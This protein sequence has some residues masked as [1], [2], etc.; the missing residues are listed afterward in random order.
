MKRRWPLVLAAVVLVLGVGAT[1]Q[2][3]TRPRTYVYRAF[4]EGCES[5][6]RY[7]IGEGDTGVVR[8]QGGWESY[9]VVL[10]FGEVASVAVSPGR[11]CSRVRCELVE[12]GERVAATEGSVG[13]LCS[14]ATAR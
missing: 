14:A 11:G 5:E 1:V 9:E 7:A 3:V 10:G 4:S 13:A 2:W 8:F 12:D 6:A